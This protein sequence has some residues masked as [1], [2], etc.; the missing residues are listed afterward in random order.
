LLGKACVF[1]NLAIILFET[2][3]LVAADKVAV[4]V[5]SLDHAPVAELA[6]VKDVGVGVEAITT[7][8]KLNAAVDKPVTVTVCPETKP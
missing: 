7:E 6:T 3:G 5:C 2:A 4:A 1:S 8:D